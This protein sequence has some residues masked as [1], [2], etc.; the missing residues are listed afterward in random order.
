MPVGRTGVGVVCALVMAWSMVLAPRVI[1]AGG[2]LKNVPQPVLWSGTVVAGSGPTAEVPECQPGCQRFDLQV[3]LPPDVWIG[4]PGG[5]QVAIRWAGRTLA[6]NV[7][8]YVYRD[9]ALVA[10][11]DG[12]I[13]TA[14]SLLIPTPANGAFQ[15]YAVYDPEGAL[16]DSIS[17]EG[18]AEVEY[19]PKVSP[20]RALLPDLT[21][22]PQRNL[23]FDP[24]GI[25]FDEISSAYPTCYQSEVAEEGARLCLRFDQIFANVGEGPMQLRFAVPTGATP[26]A[27]TASQRIFRSDGVEHFQD[28]VAG[29]VEFHSAHGHYHFESFGI[30]SLWAVDG[31]GNALGSA[32]LRERRRRLDAALVR[33]GRKVSFCMADIYMDAWA[34][35]G[36]GSRTYNAPDCLFPAFSADGYDQFVQG[37]TNGWADVYDWYL[38]DQYMEVAGVPDGVYL[39]QTVVDPDGALVEA[40]ESN[41]CGG[42]YIRLSNM[43]SPRPQATLLGPARACASSR[44]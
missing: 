24:G 18:L 28:R 34:A 2:T 27:V 1:A 23:T 13:S 12:I 39:L 17:Y 14:Q 21:V 15:V 19:A 20:V 8:L 3:D 35:K 41:N 42:V 38:P 31:E 33:N 6:D 5:V 26:P 37:I 25:F 11:S 16:S 43:G 44:R 9:G 4:K 10:K 22:R 36:D 30:S 32:P 7:K 40:N 29:D